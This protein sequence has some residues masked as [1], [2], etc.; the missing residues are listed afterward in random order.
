MNA[1]VGSPV[2]SILWDAFTDVME[3][4][5]LR[6]AKEIAQS[7][8]VSHLPLVTAIRAKKTQPYVVEFSSDERDIDLRCDHVCQKGHRIEV[9]AQPI[10]WIDPTS[11]RCPEHLYSKPLPPKLLP[12][13][14]PTN[15]PELFIT[16]DGTL[17]DADYVERGFRHSKKMIMLDRDE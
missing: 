2:P 5:T 12:T 11:K 8:G 7:L 16:E 17:Y 10:L 6:L 9:C 15:D 14:R 3:A 1:K 13:L 4:N